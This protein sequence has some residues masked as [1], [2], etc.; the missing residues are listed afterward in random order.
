VQ[1]SERCCELVVFS[2]WYDIDLKSKERPSVLSRRVEDRQTSPW[3]VGILQIAG[4]VLYIGEI[5]YGNFAS[6]Q[7]SG[8]WCGQNLSGDLCGDD[9]LRNHKRPKMFH[10][11]EVKNCFHSLWLP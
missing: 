9:T 4:D 11:D 5:L 1:R 6:S 3:P 8:P 7:S 2:M 10:G